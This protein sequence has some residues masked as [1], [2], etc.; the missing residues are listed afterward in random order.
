MGIPGLRSCR[1]TSSLVAFCEFDV[2]V[3]DESLDVV[4]SSALQVEGRAE[5]EVLYLNG[6]HVKFLDETSICDNLLGVYNINQRLADGCL[7]DA[8]HVESIDLVPPVDFLVLVCAVLNATDVQCGAVRHDH[9]ARS[10]PL[11]TSK[12]NSVQHGLIQQAVAHPF[13]DNDVHLIDALREFYLLNFA[14]ND[15]N[16]VVKVISCNDLLS[17]V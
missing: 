15:L 14:L 4:V 1:E 16:D 7:A 10:Q 5:G 6:V 13:T 8:A 17:I 12:Q 9:T 2:E 3:A 11:I